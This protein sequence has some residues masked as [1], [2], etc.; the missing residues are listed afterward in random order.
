MRKV[1]GAEWLGMHVRI[2]E[3][4]VV[5]LACLDLSQCD[6]L[7][8][9]IEDHQEVLALLGVSRVVVGHCDDGAVSSMMMAGSSR[10]I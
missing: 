10:G 6:L 9:V 2:V 7:F 3:L 1:R 4:P 8:D 5:D